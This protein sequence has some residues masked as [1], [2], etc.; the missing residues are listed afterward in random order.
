MVNA[1]TKTVWH[2]F[3]VVITALCNFELP[4]FSCMQVLMNFLYLGCKEWSKIKK[5]N[6]NS[7]TLWKMVSENNFHL[8]IADGLFIQEKH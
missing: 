6:K 2:I 1:H 7:L 4:I 5:S 8:F 3:E